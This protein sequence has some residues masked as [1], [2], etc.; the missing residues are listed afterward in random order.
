MARSARTVT[1]SLP[2]DLARKIDRLARKGGRTR[3]ELFRAAILQYI[4][5][6]ERW[7]RIFAYGEQRAKDLGLTEQDVPRLVKDFRAERRRA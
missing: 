1:V 7:D 3:S 6:L 4:E 2:P 5:R